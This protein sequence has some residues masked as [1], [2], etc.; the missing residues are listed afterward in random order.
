VRTCEA[1]KATLVPVFLSAQEPKLY[2]DKDLQGALADRLNSDELALV[3]N[4][5]AANQE[6]EMWA[7]ELTQELR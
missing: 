5:L 1:I 3:V 7:R 2:T 4:P 6:M